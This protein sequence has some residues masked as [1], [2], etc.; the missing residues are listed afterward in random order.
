METALTK[1]L[2]SRWLGMVAYS[3]TK[4]NEPLAAYIPQYGGFRRSFN[5]GTGAWNPNEEIN[6]A[7]RTW[8]WTARLN[9]SYQLPWDVVVAA[10]YQIISG[11]RWARTALFTGGTTIPSIVLNVEPIGT[12]AFPVQHVLDIRLEKRL[13]VLGNPLGLKF[14]VFNVPNANTIQSANIQ[15]GSTFLRPLSILPGRD[16]QFG[17]SYRF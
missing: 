13:K 6:S 10:N 9:G 14:E 12:R 5:G 17:V 8:E 15:S 7:D 4:R 2:S 16:I 11:E 1:R 3:A